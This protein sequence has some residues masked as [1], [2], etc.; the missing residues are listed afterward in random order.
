MLLVVKGAISNFLEIL[1]VGKFLPD[2]TDISFAILDTMIDLAM[3]SWA[4]SGCQFVVR[5]PDQDLSRNLLRTMLYIL[6]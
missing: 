2:V 3:Y 1:S 6:M 4:S 5:K